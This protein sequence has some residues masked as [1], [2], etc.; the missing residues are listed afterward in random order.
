MTNRP[1][2]GRGQVTWTIYIL[3]VT[4]HT[5][6]TA[7]ARLIKFCT[8]VGYTKSQHTDD[9]S[10]LKGAWL[11]SRDP[12]WILRPPTPNDICGTDEARIVKLCT[13]R[14]YEVLAFRW[15]TTPK[16]GM[17]RVTWLIFNFDARNHIS[18]TAKANVAK[19]CMQVE[20]IKC[21]PWDDQLPLVGVVR[22]TWIVFT[23]AALPIRGY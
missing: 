3:V 12:F 18:G 21:Q 1:W 9:K 20:Y 4:N 23:R 11:G 10:P 22:V 17:V 5:S 14:L 19:F 6:G 2:K 13:G 16:K 15:Q 7:E 8:Q